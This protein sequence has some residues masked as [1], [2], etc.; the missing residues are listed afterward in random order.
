MRA[1]IF[2]TT[3]PHANFIFISR[4]FLIAAPSIWNS[5]ADSLRSS[6]TLHSFRRHLKTQL[7]QAALNTPS[8]ILQRLRFTYVTHG[9][10]EMVLLTYWLTDWLTD[11]LTYLLTYL[12]T[13]CQPCLAVADLRHGNN[14]WFVRA[15]LGAHRTN[16]VQQRRRN[17]RHTG[18][19]PAV[20]SSSSC[21]R[22][23]HTVHVIWDSY[24]RYLTLVVVLWCPAL[25]SSSSS[26]SV[27]ALRWEPV[28]VH[29]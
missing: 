25:S 13:Y 24:W 29:V 7:Y 20:A 4:S 27:T 10:L 23:I 19:F 9:S 5:L 22:Y 1:G 21:Q 18:R 14:G 16:V 28:N 3:S 26:A 6:G 12:L 11:W 2:V 17:H 15:W 8:G